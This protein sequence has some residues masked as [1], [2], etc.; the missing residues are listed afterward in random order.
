MK[1]E[2][3]KKLK[4]F[5]PFLI[6]DGL[7]ATGSLFIAFFVIIN[8]IYIIN[9]IFIVI[10]I[11]SSFALGLIM[12]A[13]ATII[14][15]KM[16]NWYKNWLFG[17]VLVGGI[18]FFVLLLEIFAPNFIFEFPYAGTL[19]PEYVYFDFMLFISV[20]IVFGVGTISICLGKLIQ[21]KFIKKN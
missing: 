16:G 10:F 8:E 15:G 19:S 12:T 11:I 2:Y 7:I 13:D 21:I 14:K 17:F 1:E 20:L 4:R 18:F 3:R 9:I 5:I 6:L